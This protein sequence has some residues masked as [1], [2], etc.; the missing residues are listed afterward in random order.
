M[1]M[2]HLRTQ[3]RRGGFTLIE[4]IMVIAIIAIL[5]GL[6][7]GGIIYAMNRGPEAV[8]VFEIGNFVTA[9]GAAQKEFGDGANYLPSTLVLLENNHY[10]SDAAATQVLPQ[11]QSTV[12][13][14]N[15]VFARSI[16]L[17]PSTAPGGI[18]GIDWNG[19]GSISATPATLQGQHCLVLWTGGI[20]S[21]SGATML[22]FTPGSN[23]A[24]TPQNTKQQRGPWFPFQSARLKRDPSNNFM[25]YHDG[26]GV[27]PY[28]YFSS[29]KYSNDY[30]SDCPSLGLAPYYLTTVGATPQYA[31]PKGFQII[32]AG[33]DHA[34]GSGGLLPRTGATGA[35][36]D[37]LANFQ[38][39]R[40]AT[41]QN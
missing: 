1:K 36:A 22:G 15:R 32:S 25:V 18:A 6:L 39:G 9:M 26:F 34:F 19:D 23:P 28:A 8:T 33:L 12:Q 24:A 13:T 2:N 20:P 27:Q 17:K 30:T 4:L 7:V 11:Y 10:Y 35:D 41:P 5:V 31:N 3:T 29:G 37:N 14:L 21:A 16:N 38:K 40:L